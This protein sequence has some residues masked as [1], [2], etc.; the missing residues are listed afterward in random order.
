MNRS[1]PSELNQGIPHQPYA[2]GLLELNLNWYWA[3]IENNT[4]SLSQLQM[5]IKAD[6]VIRNEF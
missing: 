1:R 4:A 2:P 3:E 6:L 5:E